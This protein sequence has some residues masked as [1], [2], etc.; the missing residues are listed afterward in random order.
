MNSG[1]IKEYLP[2]L[3]NAKKYELIYKRYLKLG[4]YVE[5]DIMNLIKR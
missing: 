1:F 4:K 5:E 2:I 3:E